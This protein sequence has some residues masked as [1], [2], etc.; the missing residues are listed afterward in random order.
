MVPKQLGDAL[1]VHWSDEVFVLVVDETVGLVQSLV[2]PQ[3]LRSLRL[4]PV[5]LNRL[6]EGDVVGFDE[7]V[8]RPVVA[9]GRQEV[10]VELPEHVESD[11]AIWSLDA[12]VGL[13]EHLVKL[14]EGEVFRKQ[15]VGE[16]VHF[17]QTLQLHDACDVELLCEPMIKRYLLLFV[18][19]YHYLMKTDII[20]F[21]VRYL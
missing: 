10:V 5:P 8:G 3:E 20:F 15:L 6:S 1:E 7:P 13:A 2:S 21:D 18:K 17:D 19:L 4:C 16:S 11:S 9:V 14:V 12:V